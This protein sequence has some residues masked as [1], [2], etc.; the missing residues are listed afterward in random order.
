MENT[1]DQEV[2]NFLTAT[3]SWLRHNPTNDKIEP[4]PRPSVFR[5][6]LRFRVSQ[7]NVC[8][9]CNKLKASNGLVKLNVSTIEEPQI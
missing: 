1:Q 5:P 7:E 8:A 4:Q 3:Y 6:P 2:K 9:C